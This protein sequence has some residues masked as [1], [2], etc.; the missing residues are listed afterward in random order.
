VK[1][2][3]NKEKESCSCTNTNCA[4]H[5]KCEECIR[6]HKLAGS[7]NGCERAGKKPK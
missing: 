4:R 3:A 1:T 6:Y 7:K 2:V 5:S